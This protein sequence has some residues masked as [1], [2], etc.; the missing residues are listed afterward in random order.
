MSG[1]TKGEKASQISSKMIAGGSMPQLKVD[2]RHHVSKPEGSLTM[3][4]SMGHVIKEFIVDNKTGVKIPVSN[5]EERRN[6]VGPYL[7]LRR[8][9]QLE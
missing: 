3:Q 7:Q 9:K 8:L 5:L 2:S 1:K 6:D 4:N